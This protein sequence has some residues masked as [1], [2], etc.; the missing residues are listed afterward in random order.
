MMK[1]YDFRFPGIDSVRTPDKTRRLRDGLLELAGGFTELPPGVLTDLIPGDGSG[2]IVALPTEAAVTAL[3]DFLGRLA[4]EWQRARPV[5]TCAKNGPRRRFGFFLVPE[6]ANRDRRGYRR[7]LFSPERWT[8]MRRTL[9]KKLSHAP[10]RVYGEWKPVEANRLLDKDV[11]F[12]F[13]FQCNAEADAEVFE[14]YIREEVFDGGSE[15]DQE[16]IYMSVR[17]EGRYVF[18]PASDR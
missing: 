18:D 17:G 7:P 13:A 16:T 10:L 3:R 5:L 8:A 15:C 2:Y 4:R 1:E 6:H 9:G 11:S 14:H 12:M